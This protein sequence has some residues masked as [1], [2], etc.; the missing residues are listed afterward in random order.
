MGITCVKYT[1][2]SSEDKQSVF[3]CQFQLF[4]DKNRSR[5]EE[6]NIFIKINI[7]FS[8]YQTQDIDK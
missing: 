1:H 2:L 6:R 5:W 3:F 4:L 8:P 7:W